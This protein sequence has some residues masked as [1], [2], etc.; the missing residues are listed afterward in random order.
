VNEKCQ[1]TEIARQL[2]EHRL[3]VCAANGVALRQT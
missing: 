1:P 3:A 2:L